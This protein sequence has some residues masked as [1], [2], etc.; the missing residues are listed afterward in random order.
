MGRVVALLV[1]NGALALDVTGPAEVF[2]TANR[3]SANRAGEYQVRVVSK[4]GGTI[5]TASGVGLST[6]RASLLD[7][8]DTLIVSGGLRILAVAS[9]PDLCGWVRRAAARARR[10][11]SVCTGAFVLA[12][13]GLLDGR[14]AV[15][16]W[17]LGEQFRGR[18][19]SVK[20]DLEPIYIRDGDTWTSAGVTAGIDLALALIQD[21]LGRSMAIDIAKELVVFLHRPGGQSQFSST[22]SAQTRAAGRE[23]AERFRNLHAWMAENLARELTVPTLAAQV[24]MAPRSFARIYSETMG[25]TPAK[26]VEDLRLE[27]AS[28]TLEAGRASLKEV[29][30]QCG[31]GNEERLRRSF[32]RRYGVAPSAYRERF[33]PYR[34]SRT[35][36]AEP[37]AVHRAAR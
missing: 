26:A 23:A 34:S 1:F 20:L 7:E 5:Q 24:N 21:D 30:V 3:M 16:H 17:A 18:Y 27:A 8:I 31:F 37:I 11:C 22:L 35:A 19:P 32:S 15:T 4:D 29:A 28:R 33:G 10:I 36:P 2:A 14:R 13:A 6:E 12:E 25:V 9:D